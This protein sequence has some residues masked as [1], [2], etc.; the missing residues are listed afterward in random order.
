[1]N[2][3]LNICKRGAISNMLWYKV[4]R[5]SNFE[6]GGFTVRS[7]R[8]RRHWLHVRQYNAGLS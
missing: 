4:S 3:W 8:D 7:N 1:M 5:N 6:L 2:K